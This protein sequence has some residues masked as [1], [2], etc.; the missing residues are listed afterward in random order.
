MAIL[1][2]ADVLYEVSQF[3]AKGGKDLVF[4]LNRLYNGD[5]LCDGV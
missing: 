3:F 5:Q 4:V 1:R 2:T